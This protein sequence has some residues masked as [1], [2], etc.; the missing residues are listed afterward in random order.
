M[1]LNVYSMVGLFIDSLSLIL[2]G[3]VVLLS[4]QLA[5]R[6]GPAQSAEERTLVEER[7]HLVLLVAVI[8]LG[9]RLVN[10][11]FFYTMLHSFIRD[12]D[13]AMC[14][15]GVTQVQ[16]GLTRVAELLKPLAFFVMG[17][18]LLLHFLD[19]ATPSSSLMRTKLLFLAVTGL[20][21]AL[22]SVADIAIIVNVAPGKLVSCCTTVTDILERPTRV[23]PT[24]I[25][26]PHYASILQYAYFV[27]NGLLLLL[28]AVTLGYVKHSAS[29]GRRRAVLGAVFVF[30]IFNG[31]IFLLGQIEVHAPVIMGLPFHRCL[32]CMWQYVPDTILM[33]GLFILGT[34]APGWALIL[35]MLGRTKETEENLLRYL[36][37]LYGVGMFCIAAS[38]TMNTVHLLAV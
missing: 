30:A 26:G 36:N 10:W 27:S 29:P 1:I 7:S 25:V 22:E 9:I 2:I 18:W 3:W 13:G 31:I 15:F 11:L 32:Y 35:D 38:M 20:V 12:L 14:I 8:L 34:A 24:S 33:Y 21:A 37:G 4:L 5:R 28:L 16:R 19:R 6:W 23:V 17:A